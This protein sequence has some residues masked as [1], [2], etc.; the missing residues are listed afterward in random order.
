MYLGVVSMDTV[1]SFASTDFVTHRHCVVGNPMGRMFE[2]HTHGF[3]EIIFLREGDVSAIIGEKT[4][5]LTDNSLVIFRANVPHA[6]KV[7]SN[8]NY[9]RHNIIFDENKFANSIFNKI[10]E[11]L[12]VVDCN[13]NDNLIE[14][15][16]KID[17]YYQKLGEKDSRDLIAGLIKEVIFNLYIMPVENLCTNMVPTNPIIKKA[18]D[19]IDS[20]Y[21]TPITINDICKSI[22]VTKSHLHHLFIDNMKISP[23]KYINAKRLSMAQKLIFSGEKPSDVYSKCGFNEYVTFFRSY[24]KQYGYSPSQKDMITIESEMKL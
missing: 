8:K 1:V 20:Y 16:E 2:T 21:T 12:D 17:Y 4:Y 18:V 10:S 14:L 11:N 3:C 15:F 7:D 24:T 23:K 19:Y 9:D 22:S 5:K 6:I 13:N